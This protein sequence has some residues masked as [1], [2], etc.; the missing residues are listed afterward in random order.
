MTRP[1]WIAPR[2][3]RPPSPLVDWPDW[4]RPLSEPGW[5]TILPPD[6][7]FMCPVDDMLA[8]CAAAR[9]TARLIYWMQPGRVLPVSRPPVFSL[10]R[11]MMALGLVQPLPGFI[12]NAGQLAWAV[13][14]TEAPPSLL[15]AV[16]R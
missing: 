16:V 10:A 15:D 1:F 11:R 13:T 2:A 12:R 7:A 8:W 6:G 9:P 14:R 3:S 5:A 4:D